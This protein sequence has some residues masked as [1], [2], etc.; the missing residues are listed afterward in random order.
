MEVLTTDLLDLA[1]NG[2]KE[3]ANLAIGMD[4]RMI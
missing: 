3:P 2:P 1:I 4:W